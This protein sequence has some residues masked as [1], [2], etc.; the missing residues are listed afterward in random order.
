MSSAHSPCWSSPLR[1]KK[2]ML[3]PSSFHEKPLQQPGS[4]IARLEICAGE[5]G[6]NAVKGSPAL[7]LPTTAARQQQLRR[8]LKAYLQSTASSAH[9]DQLIRGP[10][11]GVVVYQRTAEPYVR[12][13]EK[14]LPASWRFQIDLERR[15]GKP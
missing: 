7:P 12:L 13:V 14:R 6:Q 5:S 1:S 4:V 9:C 2:V 3:L 15:T 10:C 8:R 11:I